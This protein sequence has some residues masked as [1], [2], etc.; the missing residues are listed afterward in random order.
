VNFN[1]YLDD[2]TGRRLAALARATRTPRNALIRKAVAAWLEQHGRT[3]PRAI[4]EFAGEPDVTPFES[5]RHELS[6][7][8]DDPL[9]ASARDRPRRRRK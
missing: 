1:V 3:W 5:H 4:L 7:A 2:E 6:A 8:S 9:A